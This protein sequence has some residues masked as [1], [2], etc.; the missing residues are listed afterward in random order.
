MVAERRGEV[1]VKGRSS[2]AL[3]R[4]WVVTVLVGTIQSAAITARLREVGVASAQLSRGQQLSATIAAGLGFEIP[5]W[6]SAVSD[7]K[8]MAAAVK[9]NETREM[10]I[11][12]A[13]SRVGVVLVPSPSAARRSLP[14]PQP[15]RTIAAL[16][17]VQKWRDQLRPHLAADRVS[18]SHYLVGEALGNLR[19]FITRPN[20]NR[21][22]GSI[23]GTSVTV[24]TEQLQ[25]TT[26]QVSQ[27]LKADWSAIAKDVSGLTLT[28][29]TSASLKSRLGSW[30][31]RFLQE[32]V[33][34]RR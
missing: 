34:T 2:R 9:E 23:I 24:I 1:S 22:P 10:M 32:V 8:P 11:E 27:T 29:E 19:L 28:S 16:E 4:L 5:E 15:D 25:L 13:A 18:M 31:D 30:Y 14:V 33:P 6:V 7:A 3:C 12:M 26:I 20:A 17:T 21:S